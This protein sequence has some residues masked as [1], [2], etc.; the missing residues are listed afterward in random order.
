[1]LRCDHRHSRLEPRHDTLADVGT[2]LELRRGFAPGVVTSFIRIQGRPLGVV[3][4]NP[5]H[6]GGAID[7]D[8]AD[9]AARFMQLCDTFDLPILSLVDTPGI[10]VGPDVERAPRWFDTRAGCSSPAPISPFPA[11]P[12]YCARSTASE[13]SP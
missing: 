2:V 3:A 1:M 11:S 6:L 12:F 13:G 7:A 5:T 8:G 4:N 10:M 9:K